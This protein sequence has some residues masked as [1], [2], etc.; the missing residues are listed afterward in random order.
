[1]T[2]TA[3]IEL[4][5]SGAYQ[6]KLDTCLH[7]GLCL[8]ACPTYALA[9]REAQAP[10]GRIAL[11][12]GAAEGRIA[13][14]D[15]TLAAHLGSC[16]TCRACESACPSGVRYGELVEVA[17][18][19]MEEGRHQ[20]GS[21]RLLRWAGLRQLMPHLGRLRAL[22]LGAWVY[23]R[24]GAQALVRRSGVLRGHL[25]AAEA[26]APPVRLRRASDGRTFPARGTRRGRVAVLQGCI[27][28]AFLGQVNDATVRVLQRNGFEVLIPPGQTCC[29]AAQAHSGEEE[30]ARELARQNIDALLAADVDVIISNAGGCGATLKEYPHLLRDDADYRARVAAFVA[31]V[32]DISEFLAEHT[33]EPPRAALPARATYVDSCHLRNAQK[34]VRQPRELLRAI[35]GFELVELRQPERCCGSAGVYNLTHPDMA[36]PILD[37]KLADIRDTGAELVVVS[38]TGCHMQILSGVRRAGLTARVLHV[39]EVLDEAYTREGM[40]DE[41]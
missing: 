8:P 17:R 37:A 23:Q 4:L 29:G 20:G 16:L 40:K 22:A 15:P 18:A 36:D 28:E 14:Q 33:V 27:Q 7:C 34:V 2:T 31:K 38:N 26:I 6:A 19:A 5:Q 25:R 10:R 12:R 24:S 39:V 11:M 9:G 21:E 35:P 30:L 3:A 41:G 32:R 1:M 13:L